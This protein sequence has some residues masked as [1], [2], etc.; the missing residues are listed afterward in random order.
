MGE[1]QTSQN[2]KDILKIVSREGETKRLTA[3]NSEQLNFIFSLYSKYM[4]Y[5][6]KRKSVIPELLEIY[7]DLAVSETKS[8]DINLLQIIKEM[9][10]AQIIQDSEKE[11]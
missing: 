3:L 9:Q 11:K 5:F 8:K 6:R 7:M 10:Q 2:L 4:I 1:Q